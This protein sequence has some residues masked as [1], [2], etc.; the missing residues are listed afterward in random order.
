MSNSGGNHAASDCHR[1]LTILSGTKPLIPAASLKISK[2]NLIG[3]QFTCQSTAG[4]RKVRKNRGHCLVRLC[5]GER[6]AD[7]RLTNPPPCTHQDGWLPAA[8]VPDDRRANWGNWRF[9]HSERIRKHRSPPTGKSCL[10]RASLTGWLIEVPVRRIEEALGLP[11]NSVPRAG[12][13]THESITC[14]R[15]GLG[16]GHTAVSAAKGSVQKR[17]CLLQNDRFSRTADQRANVL[18]EMR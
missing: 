6:S 14:A 10:L 8:D 12:H 5:R 15:S 9:G 16:V 4:E 11:I 1:R 13:P 18:V 2:A 17:L 3:C 7:S